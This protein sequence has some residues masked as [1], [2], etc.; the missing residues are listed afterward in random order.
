MVK[1]TKLIRVSKKFDDKLRDKYR[2][3]NENVAKNYFRKEISFTDFTDLV[4]DGF[5]QAFDIAFGGRVLLYPLKRGRKSKRIKF[6]FD[7]IPI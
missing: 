3:F 5:D 6:D 1:K 2:W 7:T 4:A